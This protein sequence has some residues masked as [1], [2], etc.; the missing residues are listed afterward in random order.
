MSRSLLD[1]RQA[2]IRRM[3][4]H[5]APTYD[6]LNHLL[7]LNVD[8]YWRWRTTQL[9]PPSGDGPILD[10]CTGTGDLALAYDRAAGGRVPIVAADFCHEM[11]TR[12]TAKTRQRRASDRIRYLEADAQRLPFPDDTFQISTVAFGLRNVSDTDR[13]IA[14]MVRVTRPGGKVAILEF[15]Q[16]RG[17]L[18]GRFYR[19]YFRW[20]L[21]LIGQTISRSKDNAYR[22]LPASVME[23][24]DGAALAERLSRQGLT[25][26]RWHPLTCGIAALYVGTK[27]LRIADCE[28]RIDGQES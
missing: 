20:V 1:K 8:H 27:P 16:P 22:Y 5:I 3:F 23:F 2:R 21:P 12:A 19:F 10:L 17:W 9:V 7:S 13:G 24:P 11:L 26:V 4:G 6:L 28:L 25:D 18:L 14:E 15:A